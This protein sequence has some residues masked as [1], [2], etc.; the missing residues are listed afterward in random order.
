MEKKVQKQSNEKNNVST[1]V[2]VATLKRKAKPIMGKLLKI[3]VI[4]TEGDLESASNQLKLIK[5]IKKE[6]EKEKE[7]LLI[8]IKESIA[9]NKR[10][11]EKIK[12]FFEPFENKVASIDNDIKKLIEDYYDRQDEELK[13]LENKASAGRVSVETYVDKAAQFTKGKIGSASKVVHYR[14]HI[15][16]QSKIPRVYMVPDEERIYTE[17]KAGKK[18]AGCVLKK[19][20]NVRV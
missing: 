9:N 12:E 18:V 11:M 8:D 16:D 3:T 2:V 20:N 7:N 4:K 6:S 1:A 5:E 14:L 17:L 10:A 13:K 19:V 15:E